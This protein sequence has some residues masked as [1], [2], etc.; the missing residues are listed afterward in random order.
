[1][2]TSDESKPQGVLNRWSDNQL[3]LRYY[4]PKVDLREGLARV[5]EYVRIHR[6]S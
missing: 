2:I 4:Q 3:M 5:L 1:V 6:A